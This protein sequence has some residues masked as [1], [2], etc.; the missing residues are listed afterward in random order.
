MFELDSKASLDIHE[1]KELVKGIRFLEKAKEQ[2]NKFPNF[3]N[4]NNIF[5]KV[6]SNK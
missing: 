1:F 3:K 6:S 5:G 4:L 2:K